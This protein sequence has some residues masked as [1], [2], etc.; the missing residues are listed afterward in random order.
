MVRG[1]LPE[2]GERLLAQPIEVRG[3]VL[4]FDAQTSEPA[5]IDFEGDD[6]AVRER[7]ALRESAKAARRGP[8]RPRLGVVAREVTLLPR[9]WQWLGDQPGGASVALRRLVDEARKTSGDEDRARQAREA[10]Y[11]FMSATLGDAPNFEEATRALFANDK[12][13]FEKL[14]ARWPRDLKQHL[15]ALAHHAFWFR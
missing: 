8:G 3:S 5:D 7:L 12:S 1:S 4:I 15:I 9:H 10:A 2:I 13:R 11:R 6:S 14:I